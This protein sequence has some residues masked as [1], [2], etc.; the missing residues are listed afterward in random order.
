[1]SR[2]MRPRDTLFSSLLVV[3]FVGLARADTAPAARPETTPTAAEKKAKYS[4]PYLLR[5]AVAPNLARLDLAYTTQTGAKT[6]APVAT[7]GYKPIEA[8]KELGF[9]GRMGWVGLTP[10]AGDS[11]AAVTNPLLFALF[12]PELSKGLRL[13]LFVGATAPV[14]GGGGDTPASSTR[15]ALGAGIAAR[16][17]MDNALY[18]T[19][20]QTVTVGAGVAWIK[21]GLTAQVDATLLQLTRVKGD[22]VDKDGSR[23][24]STLAAHLGYQVIPLVTLS[25][26]AHH[27][28]WLSTPAAV[29]ASAAA[30]DN[31]TVGA[32]LR[33]NVAVSRDAILRPGL[34]YF[35]PVDDPLKKAGSRYV[36]LDL[37]LSF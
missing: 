20:H 18:A 13:P 4:L 9:Y 23:T 33:L 32:G 31:T 30:R 19:N 8:L 12:T 29:K 15:A 34:A 22:L 37:P 1:M 10:D 27:Q 2:G 5:P 35:V 26:E 25:L 3:S 17:G 21:D 11:G 16:Q 24:N 7:V 6:F 28:R 36:Q 14:G